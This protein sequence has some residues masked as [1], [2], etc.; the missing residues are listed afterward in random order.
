MLH[1]DG[2]EVLDDAMRNETEKLV[3]LKMDQLKAYDAD[4]KAAFSS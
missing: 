2:D 4:R 3:D 1:N